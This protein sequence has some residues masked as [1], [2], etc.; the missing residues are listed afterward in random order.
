MDNYN[1]IA[2]TFKALA[3]EQRVR[4]IVALQTGEKCACTLLTD[5]TIAQS[6]LSHHMK[7][8]TASG[9]VNSR[10]AGKWTYY[11]LSD[12]GCDFATLTLKE[13]LTKHDDYQAAVCCD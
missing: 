4:I 13:L 11:Q 3:D 1:K 6:T 2:S 10:K 7:I 12:N 9:L 5:L 8:L